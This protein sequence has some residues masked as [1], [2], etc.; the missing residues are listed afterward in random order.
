[1]TVNLLVTN[2]AIPTIHHSLHAHSS[3][4]AF[5]KTT[6]IVIAVYLFLCHCQSHL[7]SSHLKVMF[8]LFTSI[9]E[10]TQVARGS[11]LSALHGPS[12]GNQDTQNR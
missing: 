5:G 10:C 11:C 12:S 7:T 6:L 3:V 2:N 4:Y 8:M 9:T 1:M